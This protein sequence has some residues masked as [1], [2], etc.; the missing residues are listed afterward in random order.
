MN[1]ASKQLRL[2][3][4]MDTTEPV[5]EQSLARERLAQIRR[6][7]IPVYDLRV[8]RERGVPTEAK[9]MRTPSDA[10]QLLMNYFEGLA[11]E[12]FIVVLLNQKNRMIGIHT[13]YVGSVHTTV[14][15]LAE[16]FLLAVHKCA[17][18]ILIA[19]NHPS[20]D[21]EPSPEDIALTREIVK[22]GKLLDIVVLD[23]LIVG[24]RRFVSLKERNL[25]FGGK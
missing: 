15:R 7:Y 4:V 14:I 18:A 11:R 2:Q 19:H 10:A 3:G 8:V 25:G 21:P 24:D 1:K 22:A 16:V 17:P 23:H 5:E 13:V 12:H 20:S 9:Q 6:Y